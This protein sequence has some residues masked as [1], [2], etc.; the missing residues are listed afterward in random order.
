LVYRY[1]SPLFFANAEDFR[2]AASGSGRTNGGPVEW[3]VLNT[4]AIVEVDIT[5]V[6]VLEDCARELTDRGLVV[7]WPES[8]KTYGTSSPPP[9]SLSGSART[10]YSCTPAHHRRRVPEWQAREA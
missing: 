1:D 8:S 4:E 3:F 6:D 2:H 5:A 9:A 7:A 10:A